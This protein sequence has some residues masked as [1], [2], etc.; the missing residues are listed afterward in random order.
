[1]LDLV[2][3]PAQG[4]SPS[5]R[6]SCATQTAAVTTHLAWWTQQHQSPQEDGGNLLPHICHMSN[7]L[8]KLATCSVCCHAGLQHN[9][10][11][12]NVIVVSGGGK[13]SW[14]GKKKKNK[15]GLTF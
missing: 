5:W 10:Q 8:K 2:T 4:S 7:T 11:F 1:M 3:Y 15:F 12:I 9:Q 13:G 6:P 14:W